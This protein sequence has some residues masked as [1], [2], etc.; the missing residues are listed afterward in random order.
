MKEKRRNT[1]S[2]LKKVSPFY[3]VLIVCICLTATVSYFSVKHKIASI[4]KTDTTKTEETTTGFTVAVGDVMTGVPDER[5]AENTQGASNE[6]S[7]TEEDVTAETEFK[8]ERANSF[9]FPLEGEII[10][11]FSNGQMVQ[12]KTMGDWRTHNGTDLK[13][14][15]GAPVKAVNNGIVTSVYDD[16]LWGTVVEVDHGDGLSVRYCGLGTGSTLKAGE[17]VKI[18]DKIGNLGNIPAESAD[19]VHLHIEML[20]DGTY[21]DPLSILPAQ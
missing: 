19:D 18:N 2:I 1:K 11:D 10:K 15:L 7:I 20:Q 3:I 5:Y 14:S 8:V 21:I 13:A 12:S 16:V 6:N 4:G 9:V 17:Q